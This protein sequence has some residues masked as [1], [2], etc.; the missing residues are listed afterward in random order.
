MAA[1]STT[2]SHSMN[3]DAESNH[4]VLT[5]NSGKHPHRPEASPLEPISLIERDIQN[6]TMETPGTPALDPHSILLR[7]AHLLKSVFHIFRCYTSF[8]AI[9]TVNHGN[10]ALS[11][12]RSSLEETTATGKFIWVEQ[13]FGRIAFDGED[14]EKDLDAIISANECYKVVAFM[15]KIIATVL[16]GQYTTLEAVAGTPIHMSRPVNETM[17]EITRG[18][19]NEHWVIL[20]TTLADEVFVLDLT[21][22][23]YGWTDLL[24]PWPEYAKD[25]FSR[26]SQI[27]PLGYLRHVWDE[28]NLSSVAHLKTLS[29]AED[30]VLRA[31]ELT[32]RVWSEKEG[33]SMLGLVGLGE[34]EYL[35]KSFEVVLAAVTAVESLIRMFK[36][37]KMF[38]WFEDGNEELGL[39]ASCR[40]ARMLGL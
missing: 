5:T 20:I 4:E 13:P 34:E 7:S 25:H 6:L 11:F 8:G 39:T 9:E 14:G 17:S 18:P 30:H 16:A 21:S 36:R 27:L 10:G 33:V 40:Q 31:M 24:T 22:A 2:T 37:D 23:Q 15:A 12:S 29:V 35:M 19:T 32:F 26:C 3:E 1:S 28:E 38:L